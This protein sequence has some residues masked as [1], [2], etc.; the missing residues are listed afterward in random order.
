ELELQSLVKYIQEILVKEHRDFIIKN[1]FEIIELTYQ[2][3]YFEKLWNFCLQQICYESDCLFKSTKFLTFN[4]SILEIILKRDDFYVN[5]EIVIWENLLRWACGQ[6][7]VIQQDI[8]KW[9]KN[10]FTVMERRL[11]R[12]IQSIRFYHIPSEDFLLKVYPFKKI[13]PNNLINNIFA[14][15]TVPNTKLDIDTQPQRSG[16]VWDHSACGS[17]LIIEDNGKVVCA[18]KHLAYSHQSVRPKMILE[19]KG[20]FEWDVVIEKYCS[21]TW[22]GVCAENFNYETFAGY[23]PTGWVLGSDGSTCS[24][25]NSNNKKYGYCPTFH[26]DNVKVTVHLDMDKRSCAFT[27]NGI[28]YPEVSGWNNLPSKLYPVVSLSYPGRFRIQPH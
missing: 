7:P 8:N 9:N 1:I 4:P 14:Y 22:V 3:E 24:D 28:K 27:V 26:N 20:I 11:A 16:Y 10:E 23:Q 2:K 17:K 21:Y 19:N 13:L 15:H 12:F 25:Y 18:Q 6:N 5:N